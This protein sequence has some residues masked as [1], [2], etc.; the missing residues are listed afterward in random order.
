MIYKAGSVVRIAPGTVING[1]GNSYVI[2]RVSKTSA[3]FLRNGDGIEDIFTS[4][5][6][7]GF[8]RVTGN[9]AV[10]VK[11]KLIVII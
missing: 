1:Y 5:I 7:D 10:T 4:N 8:W 11:N 9:W 6:K 3:Y 2:T